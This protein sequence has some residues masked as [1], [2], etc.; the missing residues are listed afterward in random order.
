M[1]HIF[2]LTILR[3]ICSRAGQVD[4]T[5]NVES[6]AQRFSQEIQKGC[7]ARTTRTQYGSHLPIR[8]R[9]GK[10]MEN[11]LGILLGFGPHGLDD[12]ESAAGA[13]LLDGRAR[14]AEGGGDGALLVGELVIGGAGHAGQLHN[15]KWM[16]VNVHNEKD[17]HNEN[18]QE[19]RK[20]PK[21]HAGVWK[22]NT[23]V[24]AEVFS[25]SANLD[26][27]ACTLLSAKFA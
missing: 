21:L 24:G 1:P 17:V 23:V 26:T 7:L 8:K 18:W 20:D 11:R 25:R 10:G 2:L 12:G 16:D 3:H 22:S 27:G 14:R 15:E 6:T 5:G 9:Y 19:C 4:A 13:G